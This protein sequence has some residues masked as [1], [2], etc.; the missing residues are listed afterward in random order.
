[1]IRLISAVLLVFVLVSF[2]LPALSQTGGLTIKLILPSIR[3]ELNPDLV[4]GKLYCAPAVPVFVGYKMGKVEIKIEAVK[5]AHKPDI[6]RLKG[7]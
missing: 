1:M 3:V 5:E 6:S 4:K 7:L 2:P